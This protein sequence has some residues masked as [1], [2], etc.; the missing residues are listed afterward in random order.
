V[1]LVNDLQVRGDASTDYPPIGE[2][3]AGQDLVVLD[4]QGGWLRILAPDR[5]H[6]HVHK[7]LVRRAAD[8]EQAAKAFA[9]E[10]LSVR[11]ALLEGGTLSMQLVDAEEA[12]ASRK[13]RADE[14][15]RTYEV[16]SRKQPL[17]RD[18][19][20]VRE[21][22][23]TVVAEGP[24]NDP[25]VV[26]A[27]GLL[28]TLDDWKSIQDELARAR[29]RLDQARREAQAAEQRYANEL[30]KVARGVTEDRRAPTRP[31][32]ITSGWVR[33]NFPV[34]G[35]VGSGSPYGVYQGGVRLFVIESDRYD[36]GEYTGSLVGVIEAKGPESRAGQALRVL[37]IARLEVLAPSP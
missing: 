17:E 12:A 15:F 9:V 25:A 30:Q 31:V 14:A 21:A 11:K 35:I 19:A 8:Q 27:R 22:L 36:L 32:Y 10:H 3:M 2:L 5:I 6:A 37:D 18:V 1:A 34:G 24:E 26:R 4:D 16:E 7:S 28:A 20:R 13:L 23:T 33:R 29:E